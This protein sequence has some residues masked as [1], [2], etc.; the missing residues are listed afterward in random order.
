MWTNNGEQEQMQAITHMKQWL[1]K[2]KPNMSKTMNYRLSRNAD[3]N[4]LIIWIKLWTIQN[5]PRHTFY[6]SS[7]SVII[8]ARKTEILEYPS[9]FLLIGAKVIIFSN[10]F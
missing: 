8:E 10:Y 1:P 9:K 7:N 2:T 3:K 6:L 5:V 4:M